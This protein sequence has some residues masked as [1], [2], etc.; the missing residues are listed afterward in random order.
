[1]AN[2]DDDN[3]AA[4]AI[5]LS[6][7]TAGRGATP[8]QQES[9]H[10]ASVGTEILDKVRK[11]VEAIKQVDLSTTAVDADLGLDSINRITL[12][13][14]LELTLDLEIDS[15]TITPEVFTSLAS[16]VAWIEALRA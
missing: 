1:M 10:E 7:A 5:P 12:I 11:A 4:A 15:G 8:H 6:E 14:E 13:A 16:L 3:R 9:V 2:Q